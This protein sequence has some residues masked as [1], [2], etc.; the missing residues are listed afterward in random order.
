MR[1]PPEEV[2]EH[3]HLWLLAPERE[4]PEVVI[5]TRHGRTLVEPGAL[6]RRL[7]GR[8]QVVLVETGEATYALRDA[9]G[10]ELA[11]WGG[12]ARVYHPGFTLADRASLHPRIYAF[13]GRESEAERG[14]A[15]R[16]RRRGRARRGALSRSATTSRATSSRWTRARRRSRSPTAARR[17][18][19]GDL[20][21]GFVHSCHDVLRIG[22]HVRARVREL[23]PDG[24]PWLDL[25]PF[26]ADELATI[27]EQAGPGGR[28]ARARAAAQQQRLPGGA[29]ARGGRLRAAGALPVRDRGRARRRAR[30][31]HR[32]PR[33]RRPPHRR[34][35]RGR[36]R[37]RRGRAA[38]APV[39]RRPGLPGQ[40]RRRRRSAR[41][42]SWTAARAS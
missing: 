32:A 33:R 13:E 27:A 42:A 6:A 38:A 25:Q 28:R 37:E 21:R 10:D 16:P 11:V 41:R 36:A 34:L 2:R 12:A 3:V 1:L 24:T 17:V 23:A 9:L 5:T 35:A 18:R 14:A 20:A 31:A 19:A 40:R 4:L 30:R 15:G 22:Q 8:A 29:A 7:G 39:R 26:Q